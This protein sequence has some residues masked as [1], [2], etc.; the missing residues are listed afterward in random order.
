MRIKDLIET[1]TYQASLQ[2]SNSDMHHKH[3]CV[4]I[5]KEG[6]VVAR[7]FNS[8]SLLQTRKWR[9]K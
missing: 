2:A 6:S 1:G 3:G 8:F 9:K 7:G 5:N 4:A